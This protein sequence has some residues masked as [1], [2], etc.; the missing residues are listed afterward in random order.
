MCGTMLSHFIRVDN[1][2]SIIVTKFDKYVFMFT[3]F[4][5]NPSSL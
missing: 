5:D 1:R 4:V 3:Y 2:K